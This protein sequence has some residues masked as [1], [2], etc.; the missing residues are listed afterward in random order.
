MSVESL[1]LSA[2]QEL[3]AEGDSAVR[4]QAAMAVETDSVGTQTPGRI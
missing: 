1:I 4:C 2:L 3:V